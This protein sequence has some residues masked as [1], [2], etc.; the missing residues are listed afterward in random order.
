PKEC[1]FAGN[2]TSD[3]TT[4]TSSG[5]QSTVETETT[6][7]T[8]AQ[9]LLKQLRMAHKEHTAAERQKNC[10]AAK[11]G[12]EHKLTNLDKNAGAFKTRIDNIFTKAQTYQS[13]NNV[14]VA[15]WD[16]LIAA[17]QAAQSKAA[18]SVAA[19]QT[20]SPSLDCTS[21]TVADNIATFRTAA[22]QARTDLISYKQA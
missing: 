8:E 12:L 6:N 7:K 16:Q 22:K 18:A 3:T 21:S 2:E 19:L 9:N 4:N 15:N 14:V 10:R 5:G 1:P 13:T 20:L 17:A 11:S